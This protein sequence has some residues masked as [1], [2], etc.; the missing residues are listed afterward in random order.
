MKLSNIELSSVRYI[1]LGE[2]G[3]WEKECLS[4][5]IVRFGFGSQDPDKFELSNRGQWSGLTAAFLAEGRSKSVATRFAN[6]CRLFFEDEGQ[7]LWI[8]FVEQRLCWGLMRPGR[9]VSHPDG[10]GVYRSLEGGWRST[11]ANGELLT[12]DRLSGA[13]TRLTSYRGTSCKVDKAAYVVNRIN[14]LKTPQVEAGIAALNQLRTSV[15]DMMRLLTPQDFELLVELVFASSGWRRLGVVG[16]TQKT[17]DI[18]VEL[19]STRERAFIQV[20]SS[21]SSRDLSTYIERV[22]DPY[23][24]MF[25]VFHTGSA[26]TEDPR[27]RVIGPDDL[28]T[29]VV[30]AGLS[31]WLIRKVS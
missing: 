13:L 7:T 3:A 22:E 31:D 12:I 24:K 10:D 27:V 9:P 14:G 4:K 30:D 5:G 11:D 20:K 17:I 21:T 8:T 26:A 15:A 23:D 16:K 2:A 25:F 29:L 28:A 19:P 1:K 18:D 6:E